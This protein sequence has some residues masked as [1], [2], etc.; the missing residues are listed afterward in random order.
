MNVEKKKTNPAQ[1]VRQ[2]RQEMQKVTWPEKKD[3]FISSA[4]VIV[5]VILFSL[6]FL[7]TDQIWSK[8]LRWIIEKGSGF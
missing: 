3:T 7:V 1:F 8:G 4:I 6:F 2:V 5:L